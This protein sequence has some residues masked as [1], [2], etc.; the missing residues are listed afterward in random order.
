VS[1]RHR[2][3]DLVERTA[4]IADVALSPGSF[5]AARRCRPL[6]VAAFRLAHGLFVAGVEPTLVVDVGANRGQFAA[7]ALHRWPRARVLSF[8]PLD[9]PAER[10]RAI[11]D[12]RLTVHQVALGSTE[13]ALDLHEHAYSASS[14]ALESL[15]PTAAIGLRR[16][17]L[18]TLDSA[19][20]GIELA[21][22]STLLKL[23]VQ[24]YEIEVL[25]GARRSL[26]L[27]QAILVEQALVGTYAAQPL[28]DSVHEVLR[29]LGFSLARLIDWRRVA[30]QVIEVDAL[31]L[32]RGADRLG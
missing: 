14:S 4:R 26:P 7:A 21:S 11:R 32:P 28:F 6:S 5:S 3:R 23:D 24:G 27:V 9:G 12:T 22:E 13:G 18:H 19:L 20:A 15:D 1:F 31:Y 17:P 25:G 8:E 30:G 2:A 16:V 29:D 10:L